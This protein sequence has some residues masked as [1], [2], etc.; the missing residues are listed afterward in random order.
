[1][2]TDKV[3]AA[4]NP[5][6]QFHGPVA[7]TLIALKHAGDAKVEVLLNIIEVLYGNAGEYEINIPDEKDLE[8]FNKAVRF[9]KMLN[10][11]QKLRSI[12]YINY[13]L[14]YDQDVISAF[15]E[16][17]LAE[18][19][20]DSFLEFYSPDMQPNEEIAALPALKLPDFATLATY[21]MSY[22]V[23]ADGAYSAGSEELY[24]MYASENPYGYRKGEFDD[25]SAEEALGAL[26]DKVA[27]EYL[28]RGLKLKDGE[29]FSATE[30]EVIF[31]K[32]FKGAP[33]TPQEL[34][35]KA[36]SHGRRVEDEIRAAV[37]EAAKVEKS[38]V[39]KFIRS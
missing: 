15:S 14:S 9:A 38:I 26:V 37:S 33:P 24:A 20:L 23:Y 13:F 25:H 32:M 2:P 29:T 16:L 39:R 8:L 19:A 12:E 5:I 30:R 7:A 36:I 21:G 18:E 1:M 17:P 34:A 6:A 28:I 10:P 3:R 31:S 22:G 27:H 4:D 35:L 11:F